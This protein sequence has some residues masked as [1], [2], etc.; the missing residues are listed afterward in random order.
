MRDLSK[1]WNSAEDALMQENYI[2]AIAILEQIKAQS[3]VLK[4]NELLKLK[5]QLIEAYKLNS[6]FAEAILICKILSHTS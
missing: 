4:P 5:K 3:Y 1:L 2:Q 6:Q